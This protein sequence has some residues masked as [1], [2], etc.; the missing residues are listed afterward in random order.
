MLVSQDDRPDISMFDTTALH[1]KRTVE[2]ALGDYL[3]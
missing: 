3:L 1:V 2:I